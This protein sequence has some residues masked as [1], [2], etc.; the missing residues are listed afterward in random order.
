MARKGISMNI[1]VIG[2]GYVGLVSG[3]C[4]AEFGFKVI[5]MD[6]NE[7]KIKRLK[8]GVIPFYEPG[9]IEIVQK[10][11]KLN[12]LE[13]TTD[14]E[15]AIK[16]A[17]IIFITVDTPSDQDGNSD[18]SQVLSV[19]RA[20]G[21][22]INEYKIIVNKSTVPIGTGNKIKKMLHEIIR[23]RGMDFGFDMVSN[24]EF[25]RE[26]SSVR[27]FMNPDRVIVGADNI[28]ANKKIKD[29][30][31]SLYK[32]YGSFVF[33]SIET[34]EMIKYASNSFLA[35]K[36]AFINEM[37]N[38]CEAVG[39]VNVS[40]V[41]FGI[42]LDKRIGKSFLNAG[43]GYGGSCLPK[44]TRA[45]VHI[46]KELG[47]NMSIID[48]VINSNNNQ[49]LKLVEKIEKVLGGV[50]GKTISIL[51]LSFKAETDDIRESVAITIITELTKKGAYLKVFDPVAINTVK[52]HFLTHRNLYYANN[53]YDAVTDAEALVI[54]TEWEQFKALDYIAIKNHLKRKLIFDF[55]NMLNKYI[56]TNIG[57]EYYG[58][59]I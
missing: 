12:K 24:P 28:E 33:T 18:L 54:A 14:Y 26:G 59:G 32:S 27:D 42:G 3:A 55:R 52:Q 50:N 38:L 46:G 44:D 5:C 9:L 30:F 36:V 16:N 15:Y 17:M 8:A 58:I 41:A 19:V 47:V 53:E 31:Q 20:I 11:Y 51:G 10:N 1:S 48:T 35:V 45:L 37:A 43:P 49:K 2:T 23:M 13:F 7:E 40:D 6:I 39:G 4:F 25:L 57:Y 22:N 21:E 29:I 56:L 34:A